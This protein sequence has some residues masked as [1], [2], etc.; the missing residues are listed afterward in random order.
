M[1]RNKNK[2]DFNP[3]IK[4]KP[5]LINRKLRLIAKK[6]LIIN[7]CDLLRYNNNFPETLCYL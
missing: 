2:W 5:Q 1:W 4:E 3:K 6:E 7:L